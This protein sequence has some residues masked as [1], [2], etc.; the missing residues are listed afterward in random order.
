MKPELLAAI[1][2]VLGQMTS[3]RKC[4]EVVR[5]V[6]LAVREPSELE[7]EEMVRRMSWPMNDEAL[8]LARDSWRQVAE[9]MIISK[10]H[11]PGGALV[12]RRPSSPIEGARK[13]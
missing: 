6:L 8:A 3:E 1:R 10:R 12:R 2:E 4:E 5:A 9:V 7:V 13:S 11:L